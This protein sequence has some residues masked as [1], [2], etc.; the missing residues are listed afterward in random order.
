[1]QVGALDRMAGSATQRMAESAIARDLRAATHRFDGDGD[2][3]GVCTTQGRPM[4]AHRRSYPRY[5]AQLRA[6]YAHV[7]GDVR[8]KPYAAECRTIALG[9]CMLAAH[10]GKEIEGAQIAVQLELHGGHAAVVRG[11]IAWVQGRGK[12]VKFGVKFDAPSELPTPLVDF[13]DTLA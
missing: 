9:G 4:Y 6:R 10:D 5:D 2:W 1:Y 11:T 12:D 13:I 7:I 8:S 3:N